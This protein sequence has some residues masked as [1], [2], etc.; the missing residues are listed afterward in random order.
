MNSKYSETVWKVG[1]SQIC[2]MVV[3]VRGLFRL[4]CTEFA[5]VFIQL[6]LKLI[7]TLTVVICGKYKQ[8]PSANGR[9]STEQFS[10]AGDDVDYTGLCTEQ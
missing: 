1:S 2:I 7:T 9:Q 6:I 5:E 8:I 10:L 3:T 4:L